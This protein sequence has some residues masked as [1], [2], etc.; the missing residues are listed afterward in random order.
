VTRRDF[1]IVAEVVAGSHTRFVSHAE[2]AAFAAALADR[3]AARSP[4]FDRARFLA[5]CRPSWVEGTGAE[6]HWTQVGAP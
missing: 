6:R 3:L 2:H 1:A 5:A 4:A